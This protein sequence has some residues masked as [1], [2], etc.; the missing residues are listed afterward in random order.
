MDNIEKSTLYIP[1]SGD[2]FYT[3]NNSISGYIENYTFTPT[4]K[5]KLI[6]NK[7]FIV[8]LIE[9][10]NFIHRFVTRILLGWRYEKI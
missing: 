3:S 1:I 9:Q 2:T 4:Y 10:P 8:N 6:V 7:N 5:Y